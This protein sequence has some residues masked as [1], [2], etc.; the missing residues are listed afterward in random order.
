MGKKLVEKLKE[1]IERKLF[2]KNHGAALQALVFA[3]I[4]A[5]CM[6]MHFIIAQM[7]SGKE[8]SEETFKGLSESIVDLS[9]DYM[10]FFGPNLK[11]NKV[12]H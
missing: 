9:L 1:E 11:N 12:T 7:N 10:K 2:N 3:E 6:A 8:L 5:H 4:S